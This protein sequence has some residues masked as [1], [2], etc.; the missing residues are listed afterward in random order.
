M[1]NRSI[2]IADA[3]INTV[4]GVRPI[5]IAAWETVVMLIPS[6]KKN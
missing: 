3:S 1:P 4:T 5:T 6:T 2:P